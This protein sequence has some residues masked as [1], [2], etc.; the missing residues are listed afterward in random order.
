MTWKNMSQIDYIHIYVVCPLFRFLE[1]N[2]LLKLNDWNLRMMGNSK[3]GPSPKP[4]VKFQDFYQGE[5]GATCI[6]LIAS[7]QELV[8]FLD[9]SQGEFS[10][11]TKYSS[12]I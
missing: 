12:K 5:E 10:N 2:T 1:T 8:L 9:I 11:S 3:F 6:F 7:H 4:F